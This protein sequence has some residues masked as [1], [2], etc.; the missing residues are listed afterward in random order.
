MSLRSPGRLITATAPAVTSTSTGKGIFTGTE[1]AQYKQAG[2]WAGVPG[3]PTAVSG[4]AGSGSVQVSF[5]PPASNG[6]ATITSYTVTSSP[7]NF[8]GSGSSSPITVSGLTNG[9]SYTFTVTATNTIGIGLASSPSSSVTP[10]IS[11]SYIVVAGGGGGMTGIYGGGGGGAGGYLTATNVTVLNQTYTITIGA[12][13]PSGYQAGDGGNSSISGSGFTTVTAIGGGQ[14]RIYNGS[15][16]SGNPGGSGGGAASGSGAVGG[17]GVYPGSTYLSQAR[18]G[19][20]GGNGSGGGSNQGGGGGGGAGQVG[21]NSPG[22]GGR[23]GLGGNGVINP[24]SGST[25]G[26]L[27][28]STYYL[29]GGGG[30]S[31]EGTQTAGYGIGGWGGGGQGGGSNISK[32]NGLVNTGGGGGGGYSSQGTIGGSGVVVLQVPISVTAAST[33]GLPTVTTSGSY[34]YYTF[35]ASGSITF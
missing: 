33:S 29:A 28:V 9:T 1:V 16:F 23:G 27:V 18:Q 20:D 30:G 22:T 17:K 3:A 5:T 6:G 4:I 10:A 12:G 34:R 31:T 21:F 13:G 7:D 32:T 8:T 35:T 11:I 19:Y 24:F 26:E 2:N 14:G 25:A 15:Y